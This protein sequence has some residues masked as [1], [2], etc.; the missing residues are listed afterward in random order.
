MVGDHTVIPTLRHAAD[1]QHHDRKGGHLHAAARRTGCCADE[2]Q[3]AHHQFC[4][5]AAGRQIDGV[6]ARSTG[7]DRLEQ[8]SHDLFRDG[9]SAQRRRVVPLHQAEQHRAADPQ[10]GRE[11]QHHLCVEREPPLFAVFA[12]L[13]PDHEAQTAGHN[14]EHDDRLYII[15][16]DVGH[17]RGIRAEPPKQVET[18]VAEGGDGCKYADPDAFQPILGHEDEAQQHR[19]EG[20]KQSRQRDDDL[21][22]FGGLRHP[23][24]RDALAQQPQIP[25]AHPPPRRQCEEAGERHQPQTADLDQEQNDRLPEPGELCPGI[26]DDQAGDAGGT[27]GR[28]HGV[29]HAQPPAPAGDRQTEQQGARRDQQQKAA[30]DQLGRAAS[31]KPSAP[32]LAQGEMFRF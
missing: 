26:P 27:G 6:H 25:E 8:G 32:L 17:Q 15:I 3:H 4:D 30:A 2:L 7:R 14:H 21:E 12:D 20:F 24:G 29:D 13:H 31:G 19:A 11:R 9:Q 16:V 10:D 23:A 5:G 22:H 1:G 28:E 18:G